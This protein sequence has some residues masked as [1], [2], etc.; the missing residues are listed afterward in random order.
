MQVL[1]RN[2]TDSPWDHVINVPIYRFNKQGRDTVNPV[3]KINPKVARFW[4]LQFDQSNGGIGSENPSLKVGWL[5]NTVIWNARG[6]APFT[7]HIGD[8]AST[9]NAVSVSNLIP[10]Y[11]LEKIK[12]I[13]IANLSLVNNDPTEKNVN[14]WVAAPDYKRWLLWAGLALG[15]F[16]LVGMA[17]SLLKNQHK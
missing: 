13:P 3:I 10:D 6:K 5:A 8:N 12:A 4:R 7:L 11:T 2:L 16:L 15:V 14:P 1:T 17:Y 9:T